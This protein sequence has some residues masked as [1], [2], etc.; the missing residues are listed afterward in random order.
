MDVMTRTPYEIVSATQPV[1]QAEKGALVAVT[2]GLEREA[3]TDPPRAVAATLQDVRFLTDATRAVY[4]RLAARGVPGR[5]YARSL[6]A[7]LA[8]GVQGIALS[9]DDPLVDE[10][11]VVLPSPQHPVVFAATDCG[12][13]GIPDL[14]RPFCFAVSRDPEVVEACAQVLGIPPPGTARLT[15]GRA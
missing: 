8:P 11:T 13:T 2:R 14:E 3:L 6:Q 15:G 7:W 9:D 12:L 10:W 4:A 1:Q 5:L